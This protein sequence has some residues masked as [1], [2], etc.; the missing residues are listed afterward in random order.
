MV[1]VKDKFGKEW[2]YPNKILES[3][4]IDKNIKLDFKKFCKEHKINKSKLIEDFYKSILLKMTG[5]LNISQGYVTVNIFNH[6]D[7]PKR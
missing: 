6:R 3:V 4:L 7:Q 2:N 5:N 1:K